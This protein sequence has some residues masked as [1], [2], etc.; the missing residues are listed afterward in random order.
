MSNR[1]K[2]GDLIFKM[3]FAQS[4]AQGSYGIL[5]EEDPDDMFP[6]SLD[7][8]DEEC[9]EWINVMI[10]PGNTKEEAQIAAQNEHYIHAAYHVSEC[11]LLDD[12]VTEGSRI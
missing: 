8:G 11:R 1:R 12:R 7:C 3:P 2:A 9:V 4:Q 5:V 10:L 6:C